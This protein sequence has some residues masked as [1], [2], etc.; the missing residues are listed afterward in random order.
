MTKNSKVYWRDRAEMRLISSEKIGMNALSQTLSIYDQ[1][2]FFTKQDIELLYRNYAQKGVLM[3]TDLKKSLNS[4]QRKIFL[5]KVNLITKNSETPV[6]DDRYLSR[7]TRLEAIKKQIELRINALKI[8]EQTISQKAYSKIINKSYNDIQKILVKEGMLKN[9]S[10]LDENVAEEILKQ[11]FIGKNYS[12][13]I[14]ENVDEFALKLRSVMGGALS[15]GASSQKVIRVIQERFN[16]GKS[17]AAR[18]VRTETNYFHNQSELNSY[19]NGGVEK[20][21]FDALMDSRTSEICQSLNGKIFKLKNAVAGENFPP[22][23][24]NCRST[25]LVVF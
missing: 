14:Y 11:S 16:V 25:T 10:K 1:A 21:E 8:E 15:S 17:N 4:S 2:L 19:K 3:L 6:F 9:F 5:Q 13:R 23:H 20:Y 12:Q 24:P 7:L 22:M 18:L